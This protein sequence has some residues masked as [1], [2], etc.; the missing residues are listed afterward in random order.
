MRGREENIGRGEEWRKGKGVWKK[1]RNG[2][3]RKQREEAE[4]E[5]EGKRREK[6]DK[7]T[8]CG[9]RIEPEDGSVAP[10]WTL[11]ASKLCGRRNFGSC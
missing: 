3:Q 1:N 6:E 4:K 8:R 11:P 7:K 9:G 2:K 10:L 5:V